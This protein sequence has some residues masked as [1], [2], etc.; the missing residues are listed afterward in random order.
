[1]VPLTFNFLIILG[2]SLSSSFRFYPTRPN[3]FFGRNLKML[4][5]RV[6]NL[7]TKQNIVIP[8]GSPLSLAAVRSGLKLSFQCKQ[9]S[10]SSCETFLDGV[11]VRTCITK[12]PEKKTIKIAKAKKI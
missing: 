4:D 2:S 5:V 1:M 11:R 7:D 8:S 9:G 10:C 3:L 12:V 6:E